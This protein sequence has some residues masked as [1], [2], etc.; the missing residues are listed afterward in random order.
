MRALER[1]DGAGDVTPLSPLLLE[2]PRES[3]ELLASAIH[4]KICGDPAVALCIE[5]G[6]ATPACEKP[7]HLGPSTGRVVWIRE[8]T[9]AERA[10]ALGT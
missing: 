9:D 8:L 4:C 3:L 10:K 2:H 7:F 6:E 5:N 1:A